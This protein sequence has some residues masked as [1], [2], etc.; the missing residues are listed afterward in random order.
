MEAKSL[1]DRKLFV[2]G[3]RISDTRHYVKHSASIGYPPPFMRKNLRLAAVEDE[4][5]R[6][7][8]ILQA[9]EKET[10]FEY[11]EGNNWGNY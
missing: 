1:W 3:C 10:I 2:N 9:C 7:M 5:V 11:S 8:N 6:V 4:T